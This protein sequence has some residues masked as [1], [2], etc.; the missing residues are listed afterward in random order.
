MRVLGPV[1]VQVDGTVVAVRPPQA[2]ALLALLVL[3]RSDV[4]PTSRLIDELWE[5]DPPASARVQ[6]QG[7]V[8]AL[9]R[10]LDTGDGQDSPIITRPTGYQIKIEVDLDLFQQEVAAGREMLKSGRADE[11]A[12]QLRSALDRW[13]GEA[14]AGISLPS[15]RQM[16]AHLDDLRMAVLEDR[17]AA[18]LA[19]GGG[20][21]L[22]TE[23]RELVADYPFRERLRGQLMT[24]LARAGRVP[25][26]LRVY[27]EGRAQLVEALGIEPSESLR[28]MYIGILRGE[29][30]LSPRSDLPT[31]HEVA[32]PHLL[33]SDLSDFTGRRALV[34][35]LTAMLAAEGERPAPLVIAVT[36]PGGVG[37]ST[38]A[39]HAAHRVRQSYPDGQLF[40]RLNGS[41]PDPVP[42]ADA[43]ARFLRALGVAAGAIPKGVEERAELY[44]HLVTGRRILVVLDDVCNEE[45]MRPLL[46]GEPGCAVLAAS[47]RRL[48]AVDGVHPA[49][50]SVLSDA[51]S[52][53]L[54][55]RIIGD[56]RLSAEPRAA[57]EL[58]VLC[59]GLPL[60]LRVVGARLA[61]R[62][63]WTLA[64]FVAR[65][66]D[67]RR[68]LDW[69]Q[70]GDVAVRA[71]IV[72]SY[73]QL[74]PDQQRLFRRLGLLDAPDF[75]AW[76]AAAVLDAGEDK[77][78]R[79]LDDL[80]DCHLVESAGRASIG[81]RYRLHDLVRLV[82]RELAEQCEPPDQVAA[83]LDRALGGWHAVAAAADDGLRRHAADPEP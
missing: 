32:V 15:V 43:L 70:A 71:S 36:G 74:R 16:A 60:A 19:T 21:E 64:D 25:D 28:D 22:I 46:P 69:L 38:L 61:H 2:R 44:R 68:R 56:D 45:Q 41:H 9:R 10:L 26:A 82:A 20:R 49:A 51:D 8:S 58:V 80:L 30:G 18:D 6:L 81:P 78:E 54:L 40:V 23:L 59:G 77:A 7:L 57:A 35:D 62:P 79:L 66:A 42:A 67:Q 83:T 4:V 50:L 73:E 55:R 63:H 14:F 11:A 37:K 65:L 27:R 24:A 1:Q 48:S 17:I 52:T 12:R 29:A 72:L 3:R 13:C 76:V 5:A 33:P 47:R 34:D 31:L 39:I 53:A 75:A